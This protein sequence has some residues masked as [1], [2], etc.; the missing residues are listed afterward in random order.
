MSGSEGVANG[1]IHVRST[2]GPVRIELL[3]ERLHRH[4]LGFGELRARVPA[5]LYTVQCTAG[6]AAREELRTSKGG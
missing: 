4:A 3:D 2:L 1:G 6:T 5:G